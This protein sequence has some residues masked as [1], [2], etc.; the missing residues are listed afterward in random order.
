YQTVPLVLRKI[1]KARWLKLPWLSVDEFQA[2]ALTDLT[3]KGNELSV[4]LVEDDRSNLPQIVTALA[5]DCDTVSNFDY[6]LLRES[7]LLRIGIKT[8]RSKGDSPDETANGR[9]HQDLIE[10]SAEK[11]LRLAAAIQSE[12]E[13]SRFSERHVFGFLAQAFA[14]GQLDRAK[15]RL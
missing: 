1:R 2:D 5:A 12:A 10:L 11:I 3:T 8:I 13:R 6:F 9:Y 15:V 7:A 14:I 4:W